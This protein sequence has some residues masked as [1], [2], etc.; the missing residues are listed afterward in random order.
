MKLNRPQYTAGPTGSNP[1]SYINKKRPQTMGPGLS[2]GTIPSGNGTVPISTCDPNLDG[3]ISLEAGE[4]LGLSLLAPGRIST[5]EETPQVNSPRRA[6]RYL[7]PYPMIILERKVHASITLKFYFLETLKKTS[8]F[9]IFN[10]FLS[11]Y[12]SMETLVQIVS[13]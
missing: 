7:P 13:V 12:S 8:N 4:A 10:S 9:L 1:G 11:F 6:L 2:S 5:R 3:G